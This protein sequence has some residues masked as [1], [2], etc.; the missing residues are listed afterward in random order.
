[1][2]VNVGR[3][4]CARKR[5]VVF[6][7]WFGKKQSPLEGA[8]AV[9][10]LK[11]YTA[12]S[13]YVYHYFYEGRRARASGVEHVFSVSADRKEWR[14]TTVTLHDEAVAMWEAAHERA[15]DA[16]ER[17]AVVKMALFQAFDERPGPARMSEPVGVRPTDLEAFIELLGL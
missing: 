1:M 8:P 9:R 12:Q 5:T 2:L 16:T 17:Y 15:L 4:W 6:R 11:I 10:R 3:R 14:H 13:G 7:G